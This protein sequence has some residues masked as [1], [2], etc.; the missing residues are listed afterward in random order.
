MLEVAETLAEGLDFIRVDLYRQ[1]QQIFFGEFTA[2][3]G[4][5]TISFKPRSLDSYLGEKWP[6]KTS[7]P[8]MG[9]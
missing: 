9:K 8:G 5:A 2:Y 4:G 6:V 3:P 7:E 1:D